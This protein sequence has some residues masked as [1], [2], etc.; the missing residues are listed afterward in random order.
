MSL[1]P[2]RTPPKQMSLNEPADTKTYTHHVS[3]FMRAAVESF[4][5]R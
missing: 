5:L 4:W 1:I 3:E 2:A